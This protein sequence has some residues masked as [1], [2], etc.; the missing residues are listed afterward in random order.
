M[1]GRGGEDLQAKDSQ[2]TKVKS[3]VGT[4]WLQPGDQGEGLREASASPKR[5]SLQGSGLQITN[6]ALTIA[7]SFEPTP[8][9]SLNLTKEAWCFF[10]P[11]GF[12][13]S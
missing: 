7:A 9:T 12:S 4:G 3:H 1:C 10:A 11:R 2:L 8:V 13:P 5:G 6:T